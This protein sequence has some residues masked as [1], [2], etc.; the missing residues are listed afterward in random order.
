MLL[1]GGFALYRGW[2]IH[3]GS[4]ALWAYGLG[5]LAFAIGL[6]RITR[7]PVSR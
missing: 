7:Q 2:K 4:E 3:T 5:A 6:W 1:L